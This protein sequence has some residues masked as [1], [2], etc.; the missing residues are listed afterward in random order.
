MIESGIYTARIV[1]PFIVG[2]L[3]KRFGFVVAVGVGMAI[4]VVDFVFILLAMEH[5]LPS[6][7]GG[8]GLGCVVVAG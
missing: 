8:W 7:V 1:G 6:K 2:E 4:C 5:F 3:A